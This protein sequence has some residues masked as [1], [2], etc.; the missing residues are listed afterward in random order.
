MAKREWPDSVRT[1]PSAVLVL[2][3]PTPKPTKKPKDGE[4]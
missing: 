3:A 1:A 2:L 4:K